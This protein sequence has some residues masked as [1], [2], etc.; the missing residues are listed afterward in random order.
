VSRRRW[1]LLLSLLGS[2]VIGLGAGHVYYG[3][4]ENS[5][6]DALRAQTTLQATRAWFALW[7]VLFGVCIFVWSLIVVAL[8]PYFRVPPREEIDDSVDSGRTGSG[9]RT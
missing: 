7:G 6:P 4:Y 1:G 2:L 5:I 9:T 3:L 8:A